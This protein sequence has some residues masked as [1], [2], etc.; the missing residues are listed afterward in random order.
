MTTVTNENKDDGA[1]GKL[2]GELET[3]RKATASD[4]DAAI[5][6]AAAAGAQGDEQSAAD[7]DVKDPVVGAGAGEEEEKGAMTKAL[8]VFDAAGNEL[9]VVDGTEMVK[10]LQTE[11]STIKAARAQENE[12]LG[13]ALTSVHEMLKSNAEMLKAQGATIASLNEQV[14]KLSSS[15]RG[16]RSVVL[17]AAAD[18]LVKATGEL[19]DGEVMA[20]A[21][22]TFKLGTGMI[23]GSDISYAETCINRGLPIP[24]DVRTRLSV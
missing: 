10:A 23:R 5:A 17:Q 19:T 13:K 15:G 21:E 7:K 6:A 18:P 20:K 12:H 16:P 8:S 14:S 4:D 2:V 9:D 22:A 1:F 3:L 11:L 24:A